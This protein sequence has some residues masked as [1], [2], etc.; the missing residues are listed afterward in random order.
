MLSHYHL[1]SAGVCS[2]QTT[3]FL[4]LSKTIII[5]FCTYK[6]NWILKTYGETDKSI[7]FS[8]RHFSDDRWLLQDFNSLSCGTNKVASHKKINLFLLF[9]LMPR[10]RK[11]FDRFFIIISY[12]ALLMIKPQLFAI[13]FLWLPIKFVFR[14]NFDWVREITSESSG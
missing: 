9:L 13:L 4:R 11:R 5:L 3:T 6:S 7:L 1:H 14:E 12:S 8:S 2:L 10:K